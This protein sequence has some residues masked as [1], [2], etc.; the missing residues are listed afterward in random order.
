[1]KALDATF[2]RAAVY[3]ARKLWPKGYDI[4][5]DHYP[6]ID[7]LLADY[8]ARGRIGVWSGASDRTVF[9]CPEA[10]YAFRA[11]HDW[12]HILL[13][14]PFDRKGEEAVHISQMAEAGKYARWIDATFDQRQFTMLA[15]E[16]IGQLDYWERFG[17]P[18]DDQRLFA[19]GY[20]AAR[21]LL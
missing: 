5:P 10:N 2:E 3:M 20:L 11:W 7:A 9:S 6:S 15:A 18:P 13:R 8:S 4:M 19:C 1:M 14:A 21:G 12:H 16:N 17:A